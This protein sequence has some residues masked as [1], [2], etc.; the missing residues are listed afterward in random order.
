MELIL[1]FLELNFITFLALIGLFVLSLIAEYEEHGGITLL[2]VICFTIVNHF[3][4][5]FDYSIFTWKNLGIYLAIGFVYAVYRSY[6]MGKSGKSISYLKSNVMRWWF[7]WVVSLVFYIFSDLL[8]D[9]YNYLYKFTSST[10]EYF[11]K[12]GQKQN[13]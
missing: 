1:T 9:I 4:G 10:F 11:Y 2:G 6:L 13:K 3:W 12:L 8:G 7:V 5:N